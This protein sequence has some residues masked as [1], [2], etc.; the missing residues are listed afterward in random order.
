MPS[1]RRSTKRSTPPPPTHTHTPARQPTPTNRP[2]LPPTAQVDETESYRIA[3]EAMASNLG[4]RDAREGISAF[5][6][7]RPPPEWST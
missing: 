7:K 6:E 5:L 3:S 2:P 1:A 4:H